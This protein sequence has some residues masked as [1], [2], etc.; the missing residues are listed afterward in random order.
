MACTPSGTS[1]QPGAQPRATDIHDRF[2]THCNVGFEKHG[3]TVTARTHRIA[4]AAQALRA[5]TAISAVLMVDDTDEA[6]EFSQDIVLGGYIRGG[7]I[8]AIYALS[9]AAGVHLDNCIDRGVT[10]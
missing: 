5:I 1:A 7:L 6:G 9:N 10:Q 2:Q 4:D 3:F 8:E